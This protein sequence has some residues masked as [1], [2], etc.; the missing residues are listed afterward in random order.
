MRSSHFVVAPPAIGVAAAFGCGIVAN[1]YLF[2]LGSHAFDMT[3]E[4]I[5]SY[6]GVQYGPTDLFYL[7]G[8][9]SPVKA[10][11]GVPYGMS[12]FPY[13]PTMALIF[14][15]IGWLYRL[16]LVGPDGVHMDT[17]RLELLIKTISLAFAL[18]DGL[19]IYAILRRFGA[20]LKASWIG[21][22]LFLLNPATWFIVSIW[23]QTQTISISF[24]L[25]AIW[26]G[27]TRRPLLS[28][29]ALGLAAFTRPQMFVPAALL[30]LYF[31][32]RFPLRS[33]LHATSWAVIG[34]FVLFLPFSL[35]ISPSLPVDYLLS[36]FHSQAPADPVTGSY[37]YVSLDTY[38]IW[39]L[40][41]DFVSNQAGKARMYYPVTANFL[42]SWSYGAA[43]TLL[44]LITTVVIAVGLVLRPRVGTENGRY[45]PFVAASAMALLMIATGASPHHF[46]LVLALILLCRQFMSATTYYLLIAGLTITTFV[47]TYGSFGVGLSVAPSAAPALYSGTNAVTAFFI[48]LYQNDR[49]ITAAAL[50]NSVILLVVIAVAF[51]PSVKALRAAAVNMARGGGQVTATSTPTKRL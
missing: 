40:P 47:S 32:R 28:W 45:V 33:N 34:L 2:Q 15:G 37:T 18:L 50:G 44:F 38:N 14:T 42:G 30:A 48:R 10:Y 3:G 31:L 27:E 35:G 36:A 12:A 11:G 29:L 24:L 26:L 6:V 17:V 7:P 5:F 9:V 51:G 39:T 1:A 43:S 23:G 16:F 21:A 25:L 19:L 20:S 4:K 41:T 49:F 13:G 8:T 22:A 46:L